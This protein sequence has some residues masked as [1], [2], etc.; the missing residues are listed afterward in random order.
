MNALTERIMQSIDIVSFIQ[1]HI[2]LKRCGK[3]YVGLCPFHPEHH[4]SFTV[5]P[6]AQLFYCF[7]CGRGGNIFNFVM[8]YYRCSF[9]EAVA[10]LSEKT[11]IKEEKTDALTEFLKKMQCLFEKRLLQSNHALA[12]L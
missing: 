10:I 12:Y 11:G 4:P 9:S 1:E 7:G 8:E 6:E 2:R 5:N 3:N